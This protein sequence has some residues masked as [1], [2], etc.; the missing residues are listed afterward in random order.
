MEIRV[1]GPLRVVIAGRPVPLPA[2]QG[3]LLAIL[4][5]YPNQ[6]VGADRLIVAL[7]GEDAPPTALRTLQ[8]H[9]FQLRRLL[10]PDAGAAEEGPTILTDGRG[11]RLVVDPAVVDAQTFERLVDEGR[12]TAPENP[13]LALERLTTAMSLWRGTTCADVGE[14]PAAAA[15]VDRLVE[16]RA[17][18]FDEAVRLRLALD[19]HEALVPELRRAVSEA[20]FREQLWADLMVALVCSGRRAEALLAYRDAEA[21]LRRELDV[22]PGRALRDLE[23]RIRDEDATL[24]PRSAP[25]DPGV[26]SPR[27]SASPAREATTGE[28]AAVVV[29]AWSRRWPRVPRRGS[30]RGRASTLGPLRHPAAA[31]AVASLSLV[32]VVTVARWLPA[33]APADMTPLA[34]GPSGPGAPGVV[35]VG[36]DSVGILDGR[37]A[38]IASVP[39]GAEPD[40]IALGA[41]SAWVTNAADGSVTRLDIAGGRAIEQI[42]VG[43]N[44]AGIA[45][46][47]GA[48]WVANSGDRTVS[49]ID[50]TVNEV[51]SVIP[52]GTAPTG[53]ATD[54]RWVWVTNRLDH[55]V[56]RIDP[57]DG[58]PT[59]FAAGSTPVGIV[60]AARSI[61]I[62]DV[63]SSA[64]VRI[65]AETGAVRDRVPVG[66]GPSAI[67][68]TP[69]GDAVWV[70]N[71]NSGTVFRI[72]TR[73]A[74]VTAAQAVGTD[75]AGIAVT[76][77]A[78]WVTVPAT[79]E[80]VKLDPASARVVGRFPVGA[81][82]RSIVVDARGPLVTARRVEGRHEG[83]TLSV[84]T[85]APGFPST[86]DPSYVE[87]YNAQ[88]AL[89]TNDALVAYKRVGGPDGMT[90]VPNLA[91]S[92][93]KPSDGGRTWTF[94]LRS[95]I[96]YSD[97]TPV[98]PS[99]VPGSFERAVIAGNASAVGAGLFDYSGIIG[100]GSC[101]AKPPCD[102][103]L[104]IEPDDGAGTVTFHLRQADLE[105]PAAITGAPIVPAGTPLGVSDLP[106][107]ATGP[108]MFSRFEAGHEARLV[109]NARFREWSKDAQPAGYP[110]EIVT[111]VSEIADPTAVV[112]SG[113][114]DVAVADTQ[115]TARLA[116]LRTRAPAQ[117]HVA[118]SQR[119]WFE[120]MNT[121]IP[122]F[123]DVRVRRAVNLAV[124]RKALVDAWGGPL[125]A[126]IT[127]Q[128]IPPE[129]AGFERYCP[130]TVAPGSGGEWLAP[131]IAAARVLLD[132]A[133]ARGRP[134]NVWGIDDGGPHA[135]VAR[136]FTDL[137]NRLG[138]RAT[139]HLLETG[140]YFA[141]LADHPEEVSMAG[142]WMRSVGRSGSD[143][144]AGIFTC[145][146]FPG[147]AYDGQPAGWCDPALDTRIATALGLEAT[148]P[149]AANALW[150]KIDAAIV[151]AA[152]AVMAFNP[153]DVVFVSERVGGFAHHPIHLIMLDQLWVR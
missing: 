110:D 62:A 21:A 15:D 120:M 129:Y 1:L 73:S 58:T 95:G 87:W 89:L 12:L 28:N 123:D 2:K 131:D 10:V 134:V 75:P 147:Y 32:A 80:I 83:G 114:A 68:A 104:G 140:A 69:A 38:V 92:I 3:T 55:T 148:D 43:V 138:F 8:S 27:W 149:V 90:L 33:S 66:E 4:A 126:R 41:G 16:L 23:A 144:I 94:Q 64:V 79:S 127:C 34:A 122:P 24:L 146:G 107:P 17:R 65:D 139:T 71:G 137:L 53:I 48:V 42:P 135:G 52:V 99:D 98:R 124:D 40:G 88:L 20:P 153:T 7:W 85:D 54:D 29:P 6:T 136:Y 82:P 132:E 97:G 103:S 93:P 9:I 11:Y 39:V 56:T 61:W 91:T 119:T 36:N 109:R 113:G 19:D 152:P 117:L 81:S 86:P 59:P 76:E 142:W 133:G 46:G 50:P 70:V 84:A 100:S 111:T 25:G 47:F 145:R 112:E 30:A 13:M 102:L 57:D 101:G 26:A 60:A 130:Y 37:G 31:L 67:V 35:V 106:L 77:D 108:Y 128:V 51:V 96:T 151:D 72:D 143:E 45:F 49:R 118:P 63:D 5:L 22:E 18:T 115:S 14:E 125:A 150:A 44:P 105:F 74:T 141:F 121:R 78:V 116:R